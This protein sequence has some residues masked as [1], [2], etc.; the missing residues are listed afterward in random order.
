VN[1]ISVT[2]SGAGGAQVTRSVTVSRNQA[3]LAIL[4][5]AA[6]AVTT[7]AASIAISGTAEGATAVTWRSDRG[8][9][10]AAQG[11]ERWTVAAVPLSPGV[12]VIRVTATDAAG[13]QATRSV[14][15][16]RR[17]GGGALP[18]LR[19]TSPAFTIVSTSLAAITLRGTASSAA[20]ISTV[21][22][23]NAAGGSGQAAGTANWVAAD[24]P[25]FRGTNNVT[26]RA[27]DESGNSAWRALTVVRR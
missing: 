8:P 18:D 2:A 4:E 13:A 17:E 26:V 16:T 12:N 14:T 21:T 19:I 10:G 7:H 25:L 23:S 27:Y 9:S 3:G 11:V 1:V 20:G 6:A 22:W 5:P 24:I 15:V